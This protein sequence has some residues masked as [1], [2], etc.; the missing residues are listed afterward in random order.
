MLTERE[1]TEGIEV[2]LWGLSMHLLRLCPELLALLQDPPTSVIEDV[3]RAVL[4]P[5]ALSPGARD[6]F[7]LTRP[8]LDSNLPPGEAVPQAE[9]HNLPGPGRCHS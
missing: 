7:N 2:A 1:L 9:G 4:E 5:P 6:I 3:K 8:E